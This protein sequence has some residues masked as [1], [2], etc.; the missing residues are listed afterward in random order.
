VKGYPE[1]AHCFHRLNTKGDNMKRQIVSLLG[2]FGLLLVAACASAQSLKVTAN[3]PFNFVVDKAT[4]PA[5]AYSIDAISSAASKTLLIQNRDAR[6]QMVTLPN[7]VERLDASNTTCLV[8]H[9]YGDRYFLSQIW[10]AGDKSGREFKMTRHEAEVATNTQ[11][12][13]EVIVLASLR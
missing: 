5:G 7:N 6:I 2:V 1:R 11:S 12:A 10:V 3:V 13:Q 4:L 8:F 9:R